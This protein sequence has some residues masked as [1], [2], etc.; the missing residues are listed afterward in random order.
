MSNI[1]GIPRIESAS[2]S[3]DTANVSFAL[4]ARLS[5]ARFNGLILLKLNQLIP[6]GTAA[7]LPIVVTSA[8]G[9]VP[10]TKVNGAAT[11][12]DITGI[13]VYLTYYDN[14]TNTLQ[15]V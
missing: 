10:L 7:T 3:V 2:V 5:F 15:L 4:N 13:G 8:N 1:N 9:N 12:A 6:T 11:V 14:V